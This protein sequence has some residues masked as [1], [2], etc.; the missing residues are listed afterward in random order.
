[1][2]LFFYSTLYFF[3]I[4][5]LFLAYFLILQYSA[6]LNSIFC[7]FNIFVPCRLIANV[8]FTVILNDKEKIEYIVKLKMFCIHKLKMSTNQ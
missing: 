1:M 4:K 7:K 5:S 2:S 8:I 3:T 6:F